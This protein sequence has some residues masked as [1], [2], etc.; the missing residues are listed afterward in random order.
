MFINFRKPA[1]WNPLL[2]PIKIISK[3]INI[4]NILSAVTGFHPK[5]SYQLSLKS[6]TASNGLPTLPD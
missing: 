3:I 2:K 1:G 4:Y 6:E 5:K